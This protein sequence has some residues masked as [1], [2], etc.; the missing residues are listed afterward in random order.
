MALDA[1]DAKII[2][3]LQENGRISMQRL[4]EKI[5][6]SSPA[7]TERV[8]KLEEAGIITGYTAVVDPEKLGLHTHAY[9]LLNSIPE[10]Q[11]QRLEH[12]IGQTQEI[13]GTYYG[14]TGGLDLILEVYCVN[15]N[16]LAAIQSEIAKMVNTVTYLLTNQPGKRAPVVLPEEK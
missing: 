13:V 5:N 9:V 8:K 7:A 2:R 1:T 16:R 14:M 15:N 11:K 10:A 12:Y 6:M 3:I 4:S